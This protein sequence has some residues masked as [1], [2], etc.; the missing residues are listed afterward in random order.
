[1]KTKKSQNGRSMIE[2]LGVLAI[3]GVL[4]V[5]GI[6][7]Y[8][9]AMQKY[10]INKTID[11]ITQLVNG[12]RTLYSGQKS[13]TGI[14]TNVLRKAKILPESAFEDSTSNNATN[15]FGSRLEILGFGKFVNVAY[16]GVPDDACIELMS[17]DWGDS[18]GL[19]A[20]GIAFGTQ[21]FEIAQN[22]SCPAS[23]DWQCTKNGPMSLQRAIDLCEQYDEFTF[24]FK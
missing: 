1:M 23:N 3:I 14:D 18:E 19:I 20:V 7:G 13:Y 15:P 8:S 11:Q 17:Q 22:P 9:K 24:T 21:V 16:Y 4:S 6:A 2:M 5:G 10:R 12:V